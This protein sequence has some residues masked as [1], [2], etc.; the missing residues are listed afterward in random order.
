M[1][2]RATPWKARDMHRH[3][4]LRNKRKRDPYCYANGRERG[5]RVGWRGEGPTH[6]PAPRP[7]HSLGRSSSCASSARTGGAG[8]F[9]EE[10]LET[11][12]QKHEPSEFY[13]RPVA[14]SAIVHR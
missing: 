5:A 6:V 7:A 8:R 11:R 3:N 13:T 10:A 1:K 9:Q 14:F 4:V 12:G 2:A